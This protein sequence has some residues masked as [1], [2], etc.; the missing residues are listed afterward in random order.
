M[1]RLLLGF[2]VM[3]FV[4]GLVFAHGHDFNETEELIKSKIKCDQLTDDQLE[5]IGEYYMELMHPGKS[6]E[7]MDSLMGGEGSESLKQMH[8]QIARRFY[9]G[10]GDE[11]GYGMGGMMGFTYPA[12]SNLVLVVFFIGLGV[13][14]YILLNEKPKNG[15]KGK[16]GKQKS[17]NLALILILVFG[18]L[19]LVSGFMGGWMMGMMFINPMTILFLLLVVV[20]LFLYYDRRG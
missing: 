8:I 12:V 1:K 20:L 10:E 13:L 17:S 9:C 15:G 16:H 4:S 7:I 19:F 3:F 5:S 6:H 11:W 14:L 18:L 2:M